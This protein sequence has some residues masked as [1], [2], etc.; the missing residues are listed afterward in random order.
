[1]AQQIIM[2]H[3]PAATALSP[4]ETDSDWKYP[5]SIC[6]EYIKNYIHVFLYSLFYDGSQ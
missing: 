4:K 2:P 6:H 1:M 3:K 5:K